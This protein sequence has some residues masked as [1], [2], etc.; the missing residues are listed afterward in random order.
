MPRATGTTE[1]T[2]R[3][4]SS[5]DNKFQSLV[6]KGKIDIDNITPKFIESIRTKHGWENR[7]ATNFRQNYHRDANTLQRVHDLNGARVEQRGES[8]RFFSFSGIFSDWICACRH[9]ACRHRQQQRRRRWQQRGGRH[10]QK[11]RRCWQWRRIIWRR[12]RRERT[13]CLQS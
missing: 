6:A 12:Q 13:T 9:F 10:W 7:T 8:F 1:H 4:N 5:D 11:R 2:T 3:W